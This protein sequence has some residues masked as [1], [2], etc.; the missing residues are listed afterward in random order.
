MA[1]WMHHVGLASASVTLESERRVV[2]RPKAKCSAILRFGLKSCSQ[3]ATHL[4]DFFE[5]TRRGS[6]FTA[7]VRPGPGD[8]QG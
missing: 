4:D 8:S 7:E 6:S 5:I 2:K 1:W 3:V